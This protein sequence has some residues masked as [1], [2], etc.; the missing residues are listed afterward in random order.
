MFFCIFLIPVLIITLGTA[1]PFSVNSPGGSSNSKTSWPTYAAP[2]PHP[3]YTP[4]I[5]VQ[6]DGKGEYLIKVF[7]HNTQK[8][9]EISLEEYLV[10]VVIAEMPASFEL[11]AIKAQA[12]AARTYTYKRIEAGI[13]NKDHPGASIC[14]DSAHCQAYK[15]LTTVTD[16]T[17]NKDGKGTMS[18][19]EKIA[20]IQLAIS[21]T[22]GLI[23]CHNDTPIEA[24]YSSCSGG[25]TEYAENVWNGKGYPYLIPV[26]STGEEIAG[27]KYKSSISVSKEDFIKKIKAGLESNNSTTEF[28]A[29]P[30]TVFQSISS[31]SKSESGRIIT[32]KIGGVELRGR[33]LRKYFSLNSTNITFEEKDNNIIMTTLG[34]G[35]GVGLSQYGAQVRAIEGLNFEE[36][37]KFYYKGIDLQR[38][39]S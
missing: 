27:E 18:A 10:G 37:L 14:T 19:S 29:A 7:D 36:I 30:A 11:E 26:K 3:S 1:L 23:A 31:I 25:M 6:T 20:K 35:H 13:E 4:D 33:D 38:I 24:L 8:I 16:T 12:V 28:N 39:Y 2:T 34:F 22:T 17:P 32:L 15:K 9:F 5:P 21:E